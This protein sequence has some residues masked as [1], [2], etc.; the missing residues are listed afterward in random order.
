[1]RSIEE[2]VWADFGRH[3]LLGVRFEVALLP[4]LG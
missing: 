4:R 2:N 3:Q 1:M